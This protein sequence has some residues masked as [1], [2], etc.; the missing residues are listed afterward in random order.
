MRCSNRPPFMRLC[1]LFAGHAWMSSLS[2]GWMHPHPHAQPYSLA[3][4]LAVISPVQSRSCSPSL[5]LHPYHHHHLH[6][7]SSPSPTHALIRLCRTRFD[8]F[9]VGLG[10]WAACSMAGIY[11]PYPPGIL[12]FSSHGLCFVYSVCTA[13]Y[14]CPARCP[15][16]EKV[17]VRPPATP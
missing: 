3:R 1:S 6:P 17:E 5:Q 14:R 2:R 15:I 9:R 12:P 10:G 8:V 13:G 16:V 11:H 7:L 4:N